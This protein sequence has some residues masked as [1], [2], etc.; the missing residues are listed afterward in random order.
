MERVCAGHWRDSP[1]LLLF[2]MSQ[3]SSCAG[4][5]SIGG[6]GNLYRVTGDVAILRPDA[7]V[8][9][10]LDGVF[11]GMALSPGSF[12]V[13]RRAF[14]ALQRTPL[15]DPISRD[16]RSD[17]GA[18]FL[19]CRFVRRSNPLRPR[20]RA[21]LLCHEAQTVFNRTSDDVDNDR[22]VDISDLAHPW[23]P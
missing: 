1:G 11:P 5:V 4:Y 3:Q 2:G 19:H 20:L 8:G 22:C 14:G 18:I 6:T 16:R 7:S 12:S 15:D 23:S 13:F 21:G 10:L 17:D 9:R